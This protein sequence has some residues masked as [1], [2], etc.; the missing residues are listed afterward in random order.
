MAIP[1]GALSRHGLDDTGDNVREQLNDIITNISPTE[2]PFH[3]NVGR[4]TSTSD[5]GDWL[6]DDLADAVDDNAHVDGDDFVG[7][8]GSGQVGSGSAGV[9]TTGGD[10]LGNY[11]QISRKDIVVTRRADT[12]KK[13]GRTSEISYQVAKAGKELKRDCE[14]AA[15]SNTAAAA[16]SGSV[17][18]RTAGIPA[19]LRTNTS[20]GATGADPTLSSTTYGYPNAAA[21][22]GTDRALTEDGLL[23]LIKDAYVQGGEPNMIMVS[24]TVKQR[25]SNYMFGSSA[26]IATQYQD[27]GKSPRGGVTAVG[28]VDTYVSDFYVLDI[29]PNRFQRD[30]DCFILDT[31]L[32]AID[33]IDSYRVERMG[34]TGDS[35]KRVLLVDWSVRSK[36]EAGSAI[37]ADVDET[38]AMTAS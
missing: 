9:Q 19:W 27:Q 24:P 23:G 7:E 22:D 28:A 20:R 34:K 35:T 17:A 11:H 10:R 26:R 29:V 21:T 33:F 25:I 16:G 4:G 31:D 2:T 13:A 6:K 32:W 1:D 3:A 12:L 37:Y 38:A 30:D 15:T 5:L 18:P 14:K 8:G 36:N